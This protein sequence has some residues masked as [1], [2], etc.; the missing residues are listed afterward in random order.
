MKWELS[1]I[2]FKTPANQGVRWESGNRIGK[3][4]GKGR[5]WGIRFITA[6]SL[7]LCVFGKHD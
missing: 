2:C 5:H 1:G 3:S 6:F 4:V 7:P